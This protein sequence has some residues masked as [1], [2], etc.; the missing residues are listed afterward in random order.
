MIDLSNIRTILQIA[1]INQMKIAFDDKSQLVN[2]EYVF[3]GKPSKKEITYQ[4]VVKLL[5][6]GH[7]GPAVSAG[8]VQAPELIELPGGK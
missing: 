2:V 7:P 6:I 4:E 8:P 5:S 1:G 3:R